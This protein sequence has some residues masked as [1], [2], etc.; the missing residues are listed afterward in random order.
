MRRISVSL[1]FCLSFTQGEKTLLS[2]TKRAQ[3]AD[4]LR[5]ASNSGPAA[6]LARDV[7]AGGRAARQPHRRRLQGLW[8]SRRQHWSLRCCGAEPAHGIPPSVV[9]GFSHLWMACVLQLALCLAVTGLL[10]TGEAPVKT[11]DWGSFP[12]QETLACKRRS[13]YSRWLTRLLLHGCF[14]QFLRAHVTTLS[15]DRPI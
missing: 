4:D 1:C 10:C 3:R 8:C 12:A 15:F 6:A 5:A 11:V 9:R 14:S 7:G 13:L 2:F